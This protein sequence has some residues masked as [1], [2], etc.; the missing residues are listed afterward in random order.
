LQAQ[1]VLLLMACALAGQLL[2]L[3]AALLLYWLLLQVVQ[4]PVAL[5]L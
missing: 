5:L 2:Q 1:A 4:L 3:A